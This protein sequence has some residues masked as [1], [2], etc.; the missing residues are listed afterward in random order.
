VPANSTTVLPDNFRSR[1]VIFGAGSLGRQ[2]V[3]RLSAV[4]AR[5]LLVCDNNRS[6]WGKAID[7]I[8][9]VSPQTAVASFPEGVFV[10]SIWHPTKNDGLTSHASE[11][12]RLGCR[13][14][15]SFIPFLWMFPEIFLPKLF[16]Q[17]PKF[18]E[19]RRSEIAAAR[20]LLDEAGRAEFDRQLAFRVSGDSRCLADPEPG[21]QYFPEGLISLTS[22]ETFVDCGAFDGDSVRDFVSISN[23]SFKQIVALEPDPANFHRLAESVNDSRVLVQPYAVGAKREKLRMSSTGASSSFSAEGENETECITLD[24]LLS[25]VRPTFIKMDIEGSEM[26]ALE[27]AAATI[28]RSRPKIAA[29]VYHHPDHLWKIPMQLKQ[30]LPDSR[31]TLR[32]HMLDGFDTVC[33]CLPNA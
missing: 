5:P 7:E 21:L 31:L 24:E 14:V 17:Q 15:V 1:L 18:F 26:D 30:L 13:D 11:L 33:Y 19:D 10:I 25:D 27:G 22:D 32:S 29:C 28:R 12:R 2:M 9:I 8:E 20:E 23:N 6:L 16:W 3:R 4:G